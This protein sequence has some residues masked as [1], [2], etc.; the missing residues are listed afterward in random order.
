[1]DGINRSNNRNPE[2]EI[3]LLEGRR[4]TLSQLVRELAC[5]VAGRKAVLG[6]RHG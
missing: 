3:F 6:V 5:R 1:M 4:M 2:P